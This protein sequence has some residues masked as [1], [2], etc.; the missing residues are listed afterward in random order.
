ME[1][2]WLDRNRLMVLIAVAVAARAATFG[3]PLVHVDEDFYFTAARLIANGAVPYVDVWDR[4][5]IGLF[6]LYLLP[7]SLPLGWGIIAYQLMALAAVVITAW[8]VIRL[9]TVAGWGRGATYAGILYVLWLNLADGQGG[10]APILYNPMVAGAAWL[11]VTNTRRRSWWQ[12][13]AAMALMGLALQVKYSVVFEGVFFGLWILAREWRAGLGPFRILVRAG[14]LAGI[15]LLPTVAVIGYYA[16]IG[17]FDAFLF[18]NF[19]SITARQADPPRERWGNLARLFL[20]LSPLMAMAVVTARKSAVAEASERRFMLCWFA[21]A[22]LGILVPGGWFDHYALPAAVPGAVCA[23]G[24][25]ATRPRGPAAVLLSAALIGQVLVIANCESR[26]NRRELA[27]ITDAIGEGTGCLW[28]YSGSP[29]I[30][31]AANRCHAT[32]YLFPSHLYRTRENGAIGV[33]QAM[34]VARILRG[35]PAVIVMRPPSIG[36]RRDIRAMVERVI[37][38]DYAVAARQPLGNEVLTIYRRR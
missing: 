37:A 20:I 6:L 15:A 18:A 11:I 27:A 12:D 14:G 26:G 22:L 38:A 3:N 10:Q 33:P 32:R 30:Y 34:E 2:R 25:L 19:E 31:A 35:A 23:A 1:A 5:P 13:A 24:F 16:S 36:E 29:K 17:Q 4:K 7:A 28:V 21:V 8:F 9:A